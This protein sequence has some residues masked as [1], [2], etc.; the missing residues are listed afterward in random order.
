M[1]KS[2]RI[3]FCHG[4]VL[5]SQMLR[6]IH[7]F[8]HT[9]LQIKYEDYGDG[10][11]AGLDIEP[12]D[13]G[14]HVFLTPGIVKRTL[15]TESIF[16][17]L[18]ER[19]DLTY[20]WENREKSLR[21]TGSKVHFI[22]S[23]EPTVVEGGV[24][25]E[26]LILKVASLQEDGVMVLGELSDEGGL[27]LPSVE[28]NAEN[29][30]DEYADPVAVKLNLIDVPYACSRGTTYH[31]LIFRGVLHYLM[32]KCAKTKF[33]YALLVELQNRGIVSLETIKYYV[34]ANGGMF[35]DKCS[36]TE[37]F[38]RFLD[39]LSTSC[40]KELLGA[41]IIS[42]NKEKAE[43]MDKEDRNRLI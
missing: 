37:L 20:L 36:R 38:R 40:D 1:F 27:R 6:E 25:C 30:F 16:Y 18:S 32:E 31:P 11:I 39:C 23:A 12:S 28:V 13:D 3:A 9:L 19:I 17:L 26:Y 15:S 10:I 42:E 43:N 41:S 14:R 7:D 8:P 22:L 2:K 35:S 21:S 24:T 33:D 29:L 34:I 4:D 5:T